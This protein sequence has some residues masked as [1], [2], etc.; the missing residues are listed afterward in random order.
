MPP[1]ADLGALDTSL[2]DLPSRPEGVTIVRVPALTGWNDTW[3]ARAHARLAPLTVLHR[4]ARV[5]FEA[6]PSKLRE[7]LGAKT[8]SSGSGD[9]KIL[10]L[11]PWHTDAVAFWLRELAKAGN[12]DVPIRLR[13]AHLT[14]G[15]PLLLA[16]LYKYVSAS[17]F[18]W[19]AGLDTLDR[20]LDD[21]TFARGMVSAMGVTSERDALIFNTLACWSLPG[22][23][24]AAP[25]ALR[26]D[27]LAELVGG[28]TEEI[29]ALLSWA[30]RLAITAMTTNAQ[31]HVM[32]VPGRLLK[33]FGRP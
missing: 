17:S 1:T 25:D 26:A 21:P 6:T 16:A 24:H 33:A 2:D 23:W 18:N 32:P 11:R 7:I 3:L 15:W 9:D 19:E 20:A 13:I 27:E 10:S 28:E 12:L 22:A 31:W 29:S 4:H 8:G 5:V 30:E 14:G